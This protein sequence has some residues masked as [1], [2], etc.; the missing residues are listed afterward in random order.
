MSSSYSAKTKRD[1]R[2]DRWTDVSIS[3]HKGRVPTKNLKKSFP[4]FRDKQ[5][6]VA[7][8]L[9]PTGSEANTTISLMDGQTN[10]WT[11]GWTGGHFKNQ[12]LAKSHVHI[13]IG[14]YCDKHSPT[15]SKKIKCPDFSL[16]TIFLTDFLGFPGTI[17]LVI[18]QDTID[19][20]GINYIYLP[21]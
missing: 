18:R 1:E 20:L 3:N 10:G 15:L 4:Y 13:H 5:G 19:I 7:R 17:Y 16:T 21:S 8:D 11:D 2:T 14:E 12:F 6:S 9:P